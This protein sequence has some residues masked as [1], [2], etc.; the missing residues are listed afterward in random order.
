MAAI[1]NSGFDLITGNLQAGL[2]TIVSEFVLADRPG[3][4]HTQPVDELETLPPAEQITWRGPVTRAAAI[5][6]DKVVYSLLLDG[7]VGD[8]DFNWIGLVADNGT[9]LA[10]AYVPRQQ[11]FKYD[12]SVM[13]NTITRN[14]VLAFAGAQ[15]ALDVHIDPQTWQFDFTDQIEQRIEER[16]SA[17]IG[18]AL[19]QAQQDLDTRFNELVP[20]ALEQV[21]QAL[22]AMQGAT[23]VVPLFDHA[24]APGNSRHLFMVPAQLQLTATPDGQSVSVAVDHSVSLAMG[25]CLVVA[26]PG[27]Q[28]ETAQGPADSCRITVTGQEFRFMRINGGWRV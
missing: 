25:D 4:V 7:N 14:F 5:R 20:P 13:G 17:L 8:F 3:L 12:G 1:I 10:V 2:P 15:T 18:P 16:L 26:P 19:A 9:L 27:E 21:D 11:K 6:P 24:S 23:Q 22:V 28:I